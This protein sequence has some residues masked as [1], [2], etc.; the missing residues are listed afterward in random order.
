MYINNYFIAPKK[1]ISRKSS[2]SPKKVIP[3]INRS[4]PIIL[5]VCD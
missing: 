1:K 2:K 3:K 5:N 4:K